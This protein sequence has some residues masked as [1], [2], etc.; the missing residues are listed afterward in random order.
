MILFMFQKDLPGALWEA[1]RLRTE[2]NQ[3]NKLGGYSNPEQ[4]GGD[5]DW[6]QDS[7]GG[8]WSRHQ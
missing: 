7:I 4:K 2:K 1:E 5:L 8:K 3:R 6:K